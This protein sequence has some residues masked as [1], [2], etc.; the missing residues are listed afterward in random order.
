MENINVLK[1]HFLKIVEM[2]F[3][4]QINHRMPDAL[5]QIPLKVSRIVTLNCELLHNIGKK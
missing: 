5:K 1:F 3:S 4:K 2:L